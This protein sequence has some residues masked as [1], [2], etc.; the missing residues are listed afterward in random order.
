MP[1][2]I[3]RKTNALANFVETALQQIDTD[4]RVDSRLRAKSISDSQN[5]RFDVMGKDYKYAR[6]LHRSATHNESITG[7]ASFN[8][9]Y[10]I[11][12]YYRYKDADNYTDSSQKV[13]DKLSGDGLLAELASKIALVDS[14]NNTLHIRNVDAQTITELDMSSLH[15]QGRPDLSHYMLITLNL[16]DT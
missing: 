2:R 16:N 7:V 8:D 9:S 4:Y 5:D 10:Q 11:E 15:K 6:I 3:K 14:E 12:V 13:F 1:N